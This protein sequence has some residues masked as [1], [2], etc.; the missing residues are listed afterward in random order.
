MLIMTPDGTLRHECNAGSGG[1]RVKK[2]QD[3]EIYGVISLTTMTRNNRR[4][5]RPIALSHYEEGLKDSW[6]TLT[7][8]SG[9]R[10]RK[11]SKLICRAGVLASHKYLSYK[12]CYLLSRGS[13]RTRCGR[14]MS[15]LSAQRK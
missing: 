1:T 15:L 8:K 6:L 13:E 3:F 7:G 5:W 4:K 10:E 2:V 11:R 12:R 14:A 9:C